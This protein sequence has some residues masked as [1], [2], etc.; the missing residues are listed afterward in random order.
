MK[1]SCFYFK[2][3]Y[4]FAHNFCNLFKF[5]VCIRKEL[6]KRRIKETYCNRSFLHSFVY[7]YK[8]F[9][10]ERFNCLKSGFSFF[11]R[12]GQGAVVD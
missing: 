3:F 7:S 1:T 5:F 11:F 10:L 6:V 12:V 4:R 2:F 9:F 8:V